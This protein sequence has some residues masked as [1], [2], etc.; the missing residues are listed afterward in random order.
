[1]LYGFIL[2]L[3]LIFCSFCVVL[4]V[5]R[6]SSISKFGPFWLLLHISQS[7]RIMLFFLYFI[8]LFLECIFSFCAR[9]SLWLWISLGKDDLELRLSFDHFHL[10]VFQMTGSF[11][12]NWDELSEGFGYIYI[13][14][15]FNWI[16][17]KIKFVD[18]LIE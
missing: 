4:Y 7:L 12:R 8:F 9:D 16:L 6:G 17:G 15:L 11:F 18:W 14:L 2:Y 10:E 13:E 1:M 5:G 3:V